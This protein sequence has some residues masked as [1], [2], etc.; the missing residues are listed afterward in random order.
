MRGVNLEKHRFKEPLKPK[1]TIARRRQRDETIAA[2]LAVAAARLQL[3]VELLRTA[4]HMGC[5]AM[6]QN[7]RVNL[8]E[9]QQWLA[10]HPDLV[11]SSEDMVGVT[12]ENFL[13]A[14]ADR[15]MRE[16]RLAVLRRDVIP[17]GE[18]RLSFTRAT[19]EMK[20]RLLEGVRTLA[21]EIGLHLAGTEEQIAWA[22]KLSEK[23][24]RD[25]LTE[26][27]RNEWVMHD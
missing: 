14:K 8:P 17:V 19:I 21:Q 1:R 13:R 5:P 11:N 2:T 4:K 22:L 27:A 24:A 16:H 12:K 10:E 26:F 23:R 3:P 9:L 25:I 6:K 18:V 20:R 15:E 7:G